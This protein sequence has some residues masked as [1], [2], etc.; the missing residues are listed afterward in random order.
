MGKSLCL[1][2]DHSMCLCPLSESFISSCIFEAKIVYEFSAE[3]V[4]APKP[5]L[6]K[7]QLY[8]RL[9]GLNSRRSLSSSWKTEVQ[10]QRFVGR[11]GSF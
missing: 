1:L 8:Y 9:S 6:F 3:R 5:T 2:T 4:V 10:N 11:V 7:G